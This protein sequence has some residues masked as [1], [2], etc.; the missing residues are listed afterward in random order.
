MRWLRL[1]ALVCFGCTTPQFL[2]ATCDNRRDDDEDGLVD[3]DDPDCAPSGLCENERERCLDGLD[4]DR[5]GRADCEVEA[6][7]AAGFCEPF[8]PDTPCDTLTQ[9]GCPIG[10]GCWLTDDETLT[11]ART[12]GAT[13]V[14]GEACDDTVAVSR[15]CLVGHT[16]IDGTCWRGCLLDGD[17]PFDSRCLGDG[18]TDAGTCTIPCNPQLGSEACEAPA[19]LCAPLAAFVPELPFRQGGGLFTCVVVDAGTVGGD[20][21]EGERCGGRSARCRRDLVCA[22]NLDDVQSCR[23]PCFANV[24]GAPRPG[25]GCPREDDLCWPTY[26]SHPAIE[27]GGDAVTLIQGTCWAPGER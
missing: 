6:C 26:P 17:C 14:H 12:E 3:C 18:S 11:C 22:P 5:D 8:V 19:A 20:R 2:E 15:G 24:E 13:R 7:V 27:R 4:N 21:V 1:F 16:C 9:E 25:T 23:T 10:M